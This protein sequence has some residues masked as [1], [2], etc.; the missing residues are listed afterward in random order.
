MNKGL[1]LTSRTI[2]VNPPELKIPQTLLTWGIAVMVPLT[3][4]AAWL[5]AMGD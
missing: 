4:T 3:D 1:L 2:A 5:P